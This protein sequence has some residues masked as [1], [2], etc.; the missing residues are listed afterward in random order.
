MKGFYSEQTLGEANPLPN[1]LLLSFEK[2]INL[3]AGDS[4]IYNALLFSF[5]FF[6][7]TLHY[8]TYKDK[9]FLLLR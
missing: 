6:I 5:L 1:P 2:F 9:F 7:Q 8:T 3:S 4:A